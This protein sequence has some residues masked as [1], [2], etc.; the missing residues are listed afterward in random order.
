MYE[1]I[2]LSIALYGCK[3][4]SLIEVLYGRLRCM[5]A[6][7]L[8]AMCRV[9][10]THS[11]Q[12][13]ISTQELGQR[14]GLESMDTYVSRRQLRWLGHVR[15]M[16]YET[17]LPHAA[18]HALGMGTAEP[19]DGRTDDDVRPLRL[20]GARQ[21]WRRHRSLARAGGGPR[22]MARDAADPPCPT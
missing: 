5:Y 11:W 9:T 3:T 19:T 6:Q 13:H 22:G 10:R 16:D 8:R 15:R 12:H 18:A 17:R 1:A 4:W 20:Q 21:V 7:H 14:M 2:V